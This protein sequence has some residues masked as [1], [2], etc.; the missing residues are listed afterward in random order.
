MCIRDRRKGE[1][2][3]TKKDKEL[4]VVS[5]TFLTAQEYKK[6]TGEELSLARDEVVVLSLI[7][8]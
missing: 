1:L 8:I 6:L 7:H 5:F 4:S 3:T 2:F